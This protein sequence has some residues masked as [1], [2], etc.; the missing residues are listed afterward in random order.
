MLVDHHAAPRLIGHEAR[1]QR[2]EVGGQKFADMAEVERRRLDVLLQLVEILGAG[3]AP[4]QHL[5]GARL[6]EALEGAMAHALVG[7]QVGFLELVDAAA[8]GGAADDV[9]IELERVEDVHDVQHDVRRAQHVAAGIEQHLGG[10]PLGRRQDLLQ[11]LR[12][13]LH[14][15]EQPHRLRHVAEAVGGVGGADV[16]R[17]GRLERLHLGDGDPLADVDVLGAGGAAA[18]AAVAGAQPFL[19]AVRRRAAQGQ[20]LE[21][22]DALHGLGGIQAD[23][24]RRRADL[25]ALAAG[26]AAVGRFGRQCLQPFRIG[27][28]DNPPGIRL[29][30][31][32]LR[33]G[34]VK[35]SAPAEA[36]AG[37]QGLA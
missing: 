4:G 37:R 21:L 36:S 25:E 23:L 19:Q 13:Q 6:A 17:P 33:Q 7:R 22:A 27:A 30:V 18:R 9:E 20:G 5:G 11:R 8:M 26:R 3:R 1:P 31:E 14:A 28:Q 15:G 35:C 12:R 16:A 34:P 2:V 24:A 32:R 29:R 10:A